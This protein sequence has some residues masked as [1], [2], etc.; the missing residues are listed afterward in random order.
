MVLEPYKT[1]IIY[2][3]VLPVLS[4]AVFFLGGHHPPPTDVA[5]GGGVF[6]G[7]LYCRRERKEMEEE[8]CRGE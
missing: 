2:L 1:V 4:V 3:I 5:R 7:R 8:K 6:V